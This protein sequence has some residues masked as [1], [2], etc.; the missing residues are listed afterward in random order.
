MEGDLQSLLLAPSMWF[1]PAF[2]RAMPKGFSHVVCPRETGVVD[3]VRN[4]TNLLNTIDAQKVEAV[5]RQKQT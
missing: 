3:K 1:P 2:L 4:R 5:W